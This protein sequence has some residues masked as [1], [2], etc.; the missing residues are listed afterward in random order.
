MDKYLKNVSLVKDIQITSE[1]VKR[2]SISLI[3]W[4]VQIKTT[5]K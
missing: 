1:H 2:C 5:V 3:V 4:E